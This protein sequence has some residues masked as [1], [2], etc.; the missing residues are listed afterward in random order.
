M[1]IPPE[2]EIGLNMNATEKKDFKWGQQV[3]FTIYP[4]PFNVSYFMPEK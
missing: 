1:Y 2:I 3:H 4:P